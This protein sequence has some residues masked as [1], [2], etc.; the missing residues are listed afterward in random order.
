MQ[1][2]GASRNYTSHLLWLLLLRKKMGWK[3]VWVTYSWWSL[4]INTC[5]KA[6]MQLIYQNT[7]HS[8]ACNSHHIIVYDANS[9][10]S[11]HQFRKNIIAPTNNGRYLLYLLLHNKYFWNLS[12][13]R[14]KEN[15]LKST[16]NWHTMEEWRN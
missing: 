3:L 1:S 4:V 7:Y 11:C 14:I 12:L 6:D 5:S 15:K 8:F 13:R 10:L 16:L 9:Q 2:H